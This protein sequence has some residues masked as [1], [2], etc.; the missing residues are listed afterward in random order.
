MVGRTDICHNKTKAVVLVRAI[1]S[2][3]CKYFK[4]K[5]LRVPGYSCREL[6]PLVPWLKELCLIRHMFNRHCYTYERLFN[7]VDLDSIIEMIEG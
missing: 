7:P 1:A 4:I 6:S 3:R 2:R 5:T